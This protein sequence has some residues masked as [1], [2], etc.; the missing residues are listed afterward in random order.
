MRGPAFTLEGEWQGG[1]NDD[2]S[3]G[4]ARELR[5]DRRGAGT[6]TAA[7]PR[8]NKDHP[9]IR[10]RLADFVSRLEGRL[11]AELRISAGAE[12]ARYG[13]SQ[14]ALCAP[15]P[16]WRVIARRCSRR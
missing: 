13:A 16:I 6:G 3:A 11:I 15:R 4:F 1:E 7:E 5:H 8:A 10:Q 14:V 9:R 2:Q 12:A